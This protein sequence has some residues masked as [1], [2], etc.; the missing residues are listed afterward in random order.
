MDAVKS[1]RKSM[2]AQ[3]WN[4]LEGTH[5]LSQLRTPPRAPQRWLDSPMPWG[6]TPKL[7]RTREMP[8]F[9]P[10]RSIHER[11]KI[12]PPAGYVSRR[13]WVACVLVAAMV[14]GLTLLS[15]TSAW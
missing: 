3:P 7:R 12:A 5:E 1:R 15:V 14:A 13:R 10:V 2:R 8:V 4:R 6:E 11:P 9:L